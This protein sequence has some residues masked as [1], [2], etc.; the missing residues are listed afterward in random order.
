LPND[1]VLA[2]L[3]AMIHHLRAQLEVYR[4]GVHE[5][6]LRRREQDAL[7]RLGRATLGEGGARVG[8][9]A[10]LATEAAA[11][12]SRLE[13][14]SRERRPSGA[15]KGDLQRRRESL[16]R[17]L[18]ELHLVA[19]RLVMAMPATDAGSEVLAIRVELAN[20]ANERE[21]LSAEARRVGEDLLA[22]IRAWLTPRAPALVA[23]VLGG[24][25]T[26]R[27]TEAHI[28]TIMKSLGL[29]LTRRGAHLVS[30]STDTLLIEYGLPLLAAA[31]CAFLGSRLAAR[32]RTAGEACRS[33]SGTVA[34]EI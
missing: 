23:M 10:A 18:R 28:R 32:W 27:Y 29:S 16:E 12:R 20:A 14:L 4:V 7:A 9:L 25:I 33:R 26:S 31:L 2:V 34:G 22:S 6:D 3:S 8:R 13:T 30:A 21:R 11:L 17:K 19:G 1:Q 5:R 15:A 24:W